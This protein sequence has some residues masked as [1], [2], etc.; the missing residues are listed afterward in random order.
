M[1]DLRD[2]ELITALA[3]HEHFARAAEE[4]GIS[5]PAFS[6]RIRN[7]EATLGVPMVK[8]GNR[9]LGFTPEG[10]IVLK[11]ARRLI[12]D[13]DG[14]QQEVQAAKGALVGRLSIGAVPTA[15]T[16]AA[17]VPSQVHL[18]H[19]GLAI[20]LLSMSST[21]IIRGIEDFTLDAGI[22]YLNDGALGSLKTVPLYD[23]EYILLVP[24]A[25][26]PR[27]S[28]TV[29]WLEAAALPLCLLTSNMRNRQII[30][31]IFAGVGASPQPV[32][33]TNAFVA[34]LTQV[35]SGALATIAPAVLADA[36][37]IAEG[38]VRLRLV[39]PSASRSIGLV[40]AEREPQP[41][42][43]RAFSDVVRVMAR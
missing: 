28:G 7:L 42:A 9:F 29:T 43:L 2:M 26:A 35:A 11:W 15:L 25:L 36:L 10:E 22:T 33:E 1:A 18:T 23:E 34:A 6:S 4:C 3:R 16:F 37:P 13:A 8:R 17:G 5:Q 40:M 19:P 14:M 39:E 24:P 20:R 38:S 30:D 31:E 12:L 21:D 32:M 27:Q 41:P